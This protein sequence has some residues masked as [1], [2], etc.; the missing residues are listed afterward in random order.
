MQYLICECNY[1]FN[2]IFSKVFNHCFF[3]IKMWIIPTKKEIKKEIK[4]IA[5]SFKKRDE[6]LNIHKDKLI[7]LKTEM[8][9]NKLK[10]ARLEG[11]LSVILNKS[12]VSKSQQIPISLNKSHDKI[13]TKVINTLRRGKKSLIIAEISKLRPS[14]SVIEMFE[15]IVKEKGLCSK[16]SFY[17]YIAS[18]SLK[19]N[20]RL[21]TT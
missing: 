21:E 11:A 7:D 5:N 4:K 19:K 14:H 16:A 8:E 18:L 10:I 9:N 17:R 3:I 2:N 15:I 6:T 1:N 12:Q 13:E 20:M